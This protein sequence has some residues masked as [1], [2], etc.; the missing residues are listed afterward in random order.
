MTSRTC[1]PVERPA[2]VN[3]LFLSISSVFFSLS[4]LSNS[5]IYYQLDIPSDMTQHS[6]ISWCPALLGYLSRINAVC[7]CALLHLLVKMCMQSPCHVKRFLSAFSEIW[8]LFRLQYFKDEIPGNFF[9]VDFAVFV[10]DS[11]QRITTL[12]GFVLDNLV[13]VDVLLCYH[14]VFTKNQL[15]MV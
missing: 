2:N 8:S 9:Y 12:D 1:V 5:R 15:I 13:A 14:Y 10:N 7:R 4:G 11:S 3:P 6:F